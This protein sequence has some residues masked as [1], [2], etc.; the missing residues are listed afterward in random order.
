V[1]LANGSVLLMGGEVYNSG[2]AQANLEIIPRIPGGD[3]T[4]YLEWLQ[5]TAPNNLYPF[6]FVLPSL[7]VLASQFLLRL[8][9]YR[10]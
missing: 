1:V 7:R 8:L 2:P 10:C 5:S 9:I 3:T 6:L 4:V